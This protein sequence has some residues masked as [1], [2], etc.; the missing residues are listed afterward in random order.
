[1]NSKAKRLIACFLLVSMLILP[2]CLRP[3]WQSKSPPATQPGGSLAQS[4]LDEHRPIPPSVQEVRSLL[5][6]HR[7]Q[8]LPIARLRHVLSEWTIEEG[9]TNQTGMGRMNVYFLLPGSLVVPVLVDI[10]GTV[11]FEPAVM[12]TPGWPGRDGNGLVNGP[13]PLKRLPIERK[14]GQGRKAE[15]G[16]ME[17]D[18]KREI[19]NPGQAPIIDIPAPPA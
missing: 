10:D 8:G 3:R 13:V 5:A 11:S 16:D 6:R 1:M 17:N 15:N 7:F 4:E 12:S 14:A 18:G 2:S 9:R 19:R